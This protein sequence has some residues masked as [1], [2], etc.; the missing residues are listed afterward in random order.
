MSID[1]KK[2][3]K[4]FGKTVNYPKFLLHGRIKSIGFEMEKGTERETYNL[5][6]KLVMKQ[7]NISVLPPPTML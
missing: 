4:I 6:R 1:S 2:C 7:Y 3:E 5:E